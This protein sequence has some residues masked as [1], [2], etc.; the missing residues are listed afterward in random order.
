MT[1][2]ASLAQQLEHYKEKPDSFTSV[3]LQKTVQN[4]NKH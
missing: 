1:V 3:A 4:Y 2:G